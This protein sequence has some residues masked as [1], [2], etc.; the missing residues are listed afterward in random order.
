[1]PTITLL[2]FIVFYLI[3]G[4]ILFPT[5]KTKHYSSRLLYIPWGSLPSRSVVVIAWPLVVWRRL[6]YPKPA[7]PSDTRFDKQN[8]GTWF[9]YG[10]RCIRECTHIMVRLNNSNSERTCNRLREEL[11][12]NYLKAA[13]AFQEALRLEPNDQQYAEAFKLAKLRLSEGQ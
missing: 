3:A 4:Y 10:R 9:S 2:T 11:R 7:T 6:S 1:M 13:E 5:D 12:G 8:P